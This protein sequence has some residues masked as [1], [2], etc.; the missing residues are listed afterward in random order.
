MTSLE[1]NE[2]KSGISVNRQIRDVEARLYASRNAATTH[3]A[4]VGEQLRDKLSS[5]AALLVA[6]GL[7]FVVAHYRSRP[8]SESDESDESYEDRESRGAPVLATLMDM[9]SLAGTVMALLPREPA[10]EGNEE[11]EDGSSDT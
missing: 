9:L 3:A 7:G 11:S 4:V 8:N 10:P 2:K 1:N 6:G 5:P